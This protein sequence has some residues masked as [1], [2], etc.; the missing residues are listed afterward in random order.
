MNTPYLSQGSNHDARGGIPD[1]REILSIIIERFWFGLLAAVVVFLFLYVRLA[2]VVPYYRSTAVL[3]VEPIQPRLLNYQDVVASNVRNL[4]YFNT[5][6][7]TLH[8]QQMMEDALVNS[9]LLER[10]NFFPGQT[11]LAAK[12][13]A[14]L[15]H[16]SISAVERSRLIQVSAEHPDPQIASDLANAMARSYIQQELDNRM[17]A[18]MQAVEWLRERSIEYREKL[19]KG[20]LALQQYRE[21]AQSVSLEEDQNIVIAKLKSL[22]ASLSAAQADRIEAESNWEA[23]KSRI[24]ELL[25]ADA[26][27]DLARLQMISPELKNPALNESLSQLR[28]QQQEV[29]RLRER[30]KEEHPTL[31]EA[32]QQERQR[33]LEFQQVFN[34][35]VFAIRNQY[36]TLLAREANLKKAL[37]DQEQESFRLAR[38]LVEYNDIKRNVDA[39]REIYES[40]IARMKEA[41]LSG[42]V[43]SEVIRLA[44]DARPA[45]APFRP[46]RPRTLIQGGVIAIG[47]G[48]AVIFLLYYTD[49]RFRRYEEIERALGTPVLT[50]LPVVRGKSVRDRGMVVYD[51]PEGEVAEAFRT[52]RAIMGMKPEN[53]K[54]KVLLVTSAHPAEGKSLVSVNLALSYA[55]D[56]RRTLLIGAD[57]R[58]PVLN[59]FFSVEK[60]YIGLSDVLS[61]EQAWDQCLLPAAIPNL[62]V[63]ACGGRTRQPAELLG[64]PRFR[65]IIQDMRNHYDRIVFDAPP[66]LGISDTLVLLKQADAVLYVVRYGVTHSMGAIQAMKRIESSGTACIGAV[67]NG[68][69]LNSLANSYYYRHYGGYAYRRYSQKVKERESDE[70]LSVEENDG[71]GWFAKRRR[72]RSSGDAT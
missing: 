30:Y 37:Q 28:A 26:S 27:S 61:G 21:D 23:I 6:I 34:A 70:S 53:E 9:Q 25:P 2:Q 57:L 66:V 38:Q 44:E 51:Q 64:N 65:G 52:L 40:M 63:L 36:E 32:L 47:V 55:Q 49:H 4:E 72:K 10:K 58:R 43:P 3:L 48:I 16:L 56:N 17:T 20:M 24:E 8:S 11:N 31:K 39:D 33:R 62:D 50:A 71:Q 5:I 29:K 67:L 54:A 46:N 19:D 41:S 69:D 22:N 59:R 7:Q 68:V 60:S 13:A 18:S 42:N 35:A 14:A 45:K 15:R 12:A 1:W